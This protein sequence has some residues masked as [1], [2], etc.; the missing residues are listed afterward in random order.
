MPYKFLKY[1]NKKL[2]TVGYQVCFYRFG[3]AGD[4][5]RCV[6]RISE[7]MAQYLR[8]CYIDPAHRSKKEWEDAGYRLRHAFPEWIDVAD[9]V[10]DRWL[11]H[12]FP[13]NEPE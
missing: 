8:D 11:S 4:M 10:I 12:G 6:M 7:Y 13:M 9:E 2:N 3:D 5:H 1:L